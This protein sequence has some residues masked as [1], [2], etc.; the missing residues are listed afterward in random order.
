MFSKLLTVATLVAASAVVVPSVH[1]QTVA[2]NAPATVGGDTVPANAVQAHRHHGFRRL[3]KGVNLTSDQ[4]GQM[5]A[6]VAKYKPQFKEARQAN[7]R[8]TMKQLR[9]Q[10][11]SDARGV[12]TPDQQATFDANRAALK[13][14]YQKHHNSQNQNQSQ[15]SGQGSNQTPSQS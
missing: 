3:M 5:K 15:P 1:A 11:M 10:M 7:D 6:I 14:Q 9:Q 4:K 13:A 12:L 2:A 8:A